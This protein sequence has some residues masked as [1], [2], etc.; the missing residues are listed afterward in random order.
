MF[1]KIGR[2]ASRVLKS[3]GQP[4][5]QIRREITLPRSTRRTARLADAYLAA[6]GEKRLHMGCGHNRFPGWFNTDIL[7]DYPDV[8]YLDATQSFRIPSNSFDCAFSEH[9]IEHIPW[10]AGQNMLR[11]IARVLKPGGVV[12]IATPDLMQILALAS[13]QLS[14]AQR[15][16]IAW[17]RNR[18]SKHIAGRD[19][20]VVVNNF[21]YSW[22]HAFLYDFECMRIAME[23]AGLRA[24]QRVG[25]G[26]S[27]TQCLR[28]LES[29]G[30]VIGNN[31]SNLY[32]TMVVEARK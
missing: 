6:P 8:A 12:R 15:D 2:A 28:N 14:Q 32:E 5:E 9:M 24:V 29:H 25:V 26:Q 16:Y 23:T 21:F 22:G 11:E 3:G 7:Q 4:I 27:T 30:E 1:S 17:S 31:F 18:Y 10:P 13:E 19:G 20:A